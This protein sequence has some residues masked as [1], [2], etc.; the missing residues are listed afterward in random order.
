MSKKDR[1]D[2]ERELLRRLL[3]K[4]GFPAQSAETARVAT[5]EQPFPSSAQN[6][7]KMPFL[8]PL[9]YQ[10]E[11]LWFLDRFEPSSDFYNVPLAW[12]LKGD[13][14]VP[15]LERSLQEVIRRHEI[16][17]TCFVMGEDEEPKQKV[18]ADRL[19]VRLPVMDLR[20]LAPGERQERVKGV[21]A[22][23][24]GKAFDLSQAPLLRVV[25]LRTG[26]REHVLGLTLHH[27]IW[28]EWSLGVF[29]EE[30]GKLYEAYGRGEKSP[31]AE[32]GMQYREYALEQREW[33]RGGR[34]QQQMK[35]WKEQLKGMPQVLELP[36][37]H[38]RRVQQ[39]FR[40]G[41][42][43]LGL[44]SELLEGLNTL[45]RAEG[46]SLFMTLLTA[47]QVLLMR[48]TGQEVFGVGTSIT[49]R[50]RT[51]TQGLIGFFLNT[52]VIRADLGSEPAFRD[53]L[54]QVRQTALDGYEHQDLPFEKLVEELA[55]DR[56]A[57]RNPLIQVMFT[58]ARPTES[59]LGPFELSEFETDIQTSKFDLSMIVYESRQ[60]EIAFNYSTDLFEAETIR[61]MLGHYEQL[62]KAVATNPEQRVWEM[63][64]LTDPERHQLE[65][66]NQTGK[67]YDHGQ[68][69][70]ELFEQCVAR[71]PNTVAVEYEGQKFTYGELNR[72]ANRLA[73]Y[74]RELGVQAETRVA[75]CLE[76]GLAMVVG[77]VAVLK[78]GGAY[79]PMDPEYPQEHLRYMLQDCAPV[80]LLTQERSRAVLG[81]IDEKIAVVDV[82]D[83]DKFRQQPESNLQRVGT[84]L[85]AGHLAYLIYTS[86]S[87]GKPKGVMVSHQNLVSATFARRLAYGELGRFLL[88]SSFS[89]DSSVAGIFGSLMYGGTLIIAP[90]DVVRDPLCLN[91]EVE[92]L[93][94]QSLLC[95][96][97]LYKHFLEYPV[98]C[99]H[100]NL[101][102]VIVAG[103]VCPPDLVAK[104]AEKEPQV[105]L[106][107]EYGPTEGT[108]W[109]TMHRC[110][111]PM[112]RES[113]PIG[114]PIANTQ[115]HILDAK[116]GRSPIGVVGE[117]HVGGAGVARGYWNRP[118]LT[119]EKFVPDP[120]AG[121]VA[122]RMYK[123][124]DLGRWRPDG[125]IEFIGRNDSQ[126][127]IRGYRVELE[128]I[129]RVLRE[130]DAVKEAVV[131]AREDQ[132]GGQQL[133]AYVVEKWQEQRLPQEGEDFSAEAKRVQD[134]TRLYDDLYGRNDAYAYA[135]Q[136]I[137]AR[138]WSSS[139]INQPLREEE[140]AESVTQTVKSIRELGGR[141]VL[142]IG[143]GI[144]L[145]LSR[146]APH[147]DAYCG[148]DV[149]VEALRRLRAHLEGKP[150]FS[151]V[152]LREG[153]A[154]QLEDLEAERFDCV[155]LNEV[156][157]H[158]PDLD[159]LLKVLKKAA[160]LVGPRGTIFLGGMRNLHLLEAFYA[161]V[162]MFQARDSMSL[163]D[164]RRRIRHQVRWE[165][166]LI[167]APEFFAGV[168]GFLPQVTAAKVQL[169]RGQYRNEITCFKYDVTLYVGYE[170][171]DPV[172]HKEMEWDAE[173]WSI[174]GLERW[175][176]EQSPDV[177][178]IKRIANARLAKEKR[179]LELLSR[180]DGKASVA[181]IRQAL[182]QFAAKE[183]GIDPEDFF[184]VEHSL[185]Y[186]VEV[187]WAGGGYDGA[188]DVIL[189]KRSLLSR[190]FVAVEHGRGEE[191]RGEQVWA[192][193][194]EF[195]NHP[196][197]EARLRG[198][199]SRELIE[200]LRRGLKERLPE[201]M[202]P[203]AFVRLES[204]PLTANGKVDRQALPEVGELELSE[205]G[206]GYEAPRAGMEEQLAEV[207]TTVLRVTRV[208]RRDHFFRSGGHSLLAASMVSRFRNIFGI[209]VPVRA[210]FESPTIA[211]LAEVIEH[212]L[213]LQ[214]AQTG[215][216]AIASKL[217]PSTSRPSLFPLSYQQEQLWFLDRFEPSS[218][219]YNV[220]LAWT[221]KGDLDVSTL[222][223][224][225]QE[226][227][228]RHEI[229]RTCFVIGED[230][231]PRQK[232]VEK[233]D[234]MLPVVDL[235]KL[236]AGQRDQLARRVLTQEGGKAFD[237]SRAPLLRAMMVRME[238]RQH[239]LGL[240]LHHIVSDDRSLGVL[241]KELGE[242]YGAY[243]N[244]EDSPLPELGMQYGDYALEQREGLRE[245]KF[246]QQ[247]EYWKKELKGMPQV[248]ELPTDHVRPARQ[249]FRGG[250]EQII[251]QSDL[252]DGLKTLGREEKTSSFMALL[253]ILQ[254]LL[255]RY[256][257]QENF[258]V[259]T[260]VAN[261][262]RIETEQTIG[263]FLNTLVIR[264]NLE[265]EPTF[266]EVLRRVRE[267]VLGGY[268][269]QDLAFEK[270]V[271]ELAPDRDVSRTPIFQVIFTW[272]GESDKLEFGDLELGGFAV[273]LDM[274]KFD[275]TMSVS[276]TAQG[277]AVAINYATDL[278]EAET[279]RR[280]LGHYERL[281]KAV[282]ENAA[283]H[284]WRLPLLTGQEIEQLEQWNQTARDYALDKTIAGLFEE[285]A[286]RTRNA[287][288][289]E[290]EQQEL[291]YGDLNRQANRLA[292]YLIALGVKPD[293]LVAICVERSLEMVVGLLAVMKAGGAYVPLDPAYPEERLRFMLEDCRPAVLLTQGHLRGL[294]TGINES[295]RVIDLGSMETWSDQPE[296]NPEHDAIGLTAANL[297]Y[298][299]YTSGSTGTPKAVAMPLRAATNMLVWQMNESMP[300]APQRTLQFA[301]LG[302]DV[303][304]QEIFS[305]L[306]AGGTLVL[307]D[308]EKRRNS[309]DLTRYV[310]EKG[311]Q[312]LFL[313][314]V[315]LRMLAEGV[316]QIG[317]ALKQGE[318]FDCALQEINVAGE[319][320]RI[321]H[322]VRGLFKR[323]N[324]C[325]LNNHYGPTE[326]HA[327]SAFHL[328]SEE[329]NWPLLP[330]IGQPIANAHIYLLDKHE[331]LVP[332]GVTGE[333]YIGGAGVARGY[334]NR[335]ELMAGRF[336]K[337]P[338]AKE[339]EAR[340][341]RSGDIGRW[342]PDGTIEFI[343][344]NDSQ[345]KIR[346]YRV[347]LGE[348]EARL[349]QQ[350]GVRN[351]AVVAKTGTNGNRRLVAYVVG[352]REG[353]DLRRDLKGKLPGYMIPS[354]IVTLP[355]LPLSGNGKV[356]REVLEKLEDLG[357]G[358]QDYE[359]PRTALEERLS[360]TWAETLGITR[361]GRHDNFFDLGGHSLLAT[362]LVTRMENIFE[363]GVPVRALFESPT[364]AELAEQIE[365]GLKLQTRKSAE[366]AKGGTRALITSARRPS[367][368][369]LSYQQEQLWFLD[370][371]NPGNAFY[372]VPM[373]WGLKGDIDVSRLERSLQAVVRRHEI[374]R[375]CFVMGED[376]EPRQKVVESLDMPM[377]VVDL[378]KLEA[379]EREEQARRVLT[380]EAGKAFDLSR[381]P[382][383]RAIL[384]RTEDREHI[385]GLTLHHIVSD[386]WSLGVLMEELGK[387]YQAYGKGEDSPLP[388]LGMQY[389][390][391]AIEQ[392]EGL[393]EGKFQQ[394]MEYWKKELKG[395]P[396]VLEL[397]TD[398][399]RPA[400]ESFRGGTEQRIL[401]SD[402]LDGLH[403]LRRE[404]KASLLM[405]ML[406]AFQVLLMRYS[407]QDD[408]GI[409]TVVANRRRPETKGLIGFF[410][411]TL[412]IRANLGGEPT[413]RK[414]LRQVRERVLDG[415][416]HQDLAF[417]KLVEELAPDR[418]V[419][420][421]PV[422]QVA[423]ILR[424]VIAGKSEP[425]GLELVPFG[426]D[427]GT[428]K[429]DL[430][431]GVEEAAENAVIS[432]NYSADLFEAETIRHMLEHYECLLEGIVADVDQPVWALPMMSKLD[433]K[434]L[435]NWNCSSLVSR[436]EKNIVEIFDAQAQCTPQEPV[437]I[438]VETQ[439]SYAELNR[440]A[441]Q[442]G[443]YLARLGVTPEARVG[444]FMPH[445][446]E[447]MVAVL[448]VL[449]AGGA[450]LPLDVLNPKDRLRSI[451]D[452]S[453]TAMLLT[454][455]GLRKRLPQ[456]NA[457]VLCLDL[458]WEVIEQQSTTNPEVQIN[459]QN[460]ACVI[461]TAA[462]EERAK[463]LMIEHN[464]LMDLALA[465]E[466]ADPANQNG[467]A[468]QNGCPE[469]WTHLTSSS[470][471][472]GTSAFFTPVAEG[473]RARFKPSGNTEIYILDPHL[474]PVAIGVPGE[475]WIAGPAAGRAYLGWPSLTAEKFRP[476]PFK[477]EMGAR[478]CGSGE[479]ARYREDG[480]VEFLGRFDD[481][482]EVQGLQV[483][484]GEIETALTNYENVREAVVVVR[485][486]G[487][488][489]AYIVVCDGKRLGQN[490][491]RSHLDSRL[492]AYMI[493][494]AFITLQEL[495]RNAR[496]EVDRAAL[497]VLVQEQLT[498]EF[499]LPRTE[500]EQT[501]ASAWQA[502]L[503]IDQVGV[504]DNFFDLGGHSL[505]MIRLHQKLR[506]ELPGEIELLHL[507]QFPTIGSLVRF[508]HTGYNF[509]GKSR[510]T[511]ERAGRQK[512]AV[513]KLKRMHTA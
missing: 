213:K 450:Y 307:I 207:W 326:T 78:A 512:G 16:L 257:G 148:L 427:P 117:L 462:S 34:F 71:T 390:E 449:K 235:R 30:W 396:Q 346:G 57:A 506:A 193:E 233:L 188:Y 256:T 202:I 171:I 457:R 393:R 49:T 309:T 277:A 406:A 141:R 502:I 212:G 316:A 402:L 48:Y 7:K 152:V 318:R 367:F 279:I 330:P 183:D 24:A 140:I 169:K 448:G 23:E 451:I 492:P 501:I 308:E 373:T 14:N 363:I 70:G 260:P 504:H 306:G 376:E 126:V 340:M 53:A 6:S 163:E 64:L 475:L 115:I 500:L 21:I 432:M 146:I 467:H 159:Y 220:P 473:Q 498:K 168:N 138:V 355:E 189:T 81:G 479:R 106:F 422:F 493:P 156:A 121:N 145:L 211:E 28:D 379:G 438:S 431:L 398:H 221:L 265:G 110:V 62:L 232:V 284:V 26:E 47:F 425:G 366:G 510:E 54:R 378:R 347:E 65:Q 275:L 251:L 191:G 25:L 93:G 335:P 369:P 375:T 420:R 61:R 172:D 181:E 229:L 92:R 187:S 460:L 40:G 60:A 484:L 495:P 435:S 195:A 380:E 42:L 478:M 505:L 331:Q 416:E 41:M 95:V 91:Q 455:E 263:F 77:L 317:A 497:S 58:L 385:L 324:H 217:A 264:A 86:G 137:N 182:G 351:C 18:A 314:Y 328:D 194:A 350:S 310:M 36:T 388:E 136:A 336:V 85:Q 312:R 173:K 299:I 204:L 88:L 158:F 215:D 84:G 441:N 387:L 491:V 216:T 22:E 5:Q 160:E 103:E 332:L 143:C 488:L 66:W 11:Q 352:E 426:L 445:S 243:G 20:E 29:I 223:R 96:P 405:I 464:G 133:V 486:N 490:E 395:M 259:G 494:G 144:G 482:A 381:P 132:A 476:N 125:I 203:S 404:E 274:S 131:T 394:Q 371:F 362:L 304:F 384:V 10:Q 209:D 419:S 368:F 408:F 282:V 270:L 162:Q 458:E 305:T 389:G 228:R 119:A 298:V 296:S 134:F 471:L 15:I 507:F 170:R 245:G 69:A 32:L 383:L 481:R 196:M 219:F 89:F 334:L 13:L 477:S 17:R 122:A 46:A 268:E 82:N 483:E 499:V 300:A 333:L 107:N 206:E 338:F 377:P 417:E 192:A 456:T 12:T 56:D 374:L 391:Y 234:V 365:H 150:E 468:R 267:A 164:L 474:Q 247:M 433:E 409:G 442:V 466:A 513:Q 240:T 511:R 98:R 4:E 73:H 237:L 261:R 184:S 487:D 345:V 301:A 76:R 437:V 428:S 290:Y 302:F 176:Q 190:D 100:K 225:L 412:V 271:E 50:S 101:S 186:Q 111:H 503:G 201:H 31:L 2:E 87:T 166:D 142:E 354:V 43:H 174:R 139:Y 51:N 112:G 45:A 90:R 329:E 415:Y 39:S 322:K 120:L 297:V 293:V 370:R 227:V 447:M 465:H 439:L 400:R 224:S 286:S 151:H 287:V 99:E 280:M 3:E 210:I 470:F 135:D 313:P 276:E 198:Q 157:Q 266:R 430:I 80:V 453:D 323:L 461:Y 401:Q 392:R 273:D 127:K 238:D 480:T 403:A 321:D 59:E 155:V 424:R 258:G 179:L 489:V 358:S 55:P 348:I 272:L 485:P 178:R 386:D 128:E 262:K 359:A 343:G 421:S 226:V 418:D 208:G 153:A 414:V 8:F 315:G 319:Q 469:I 67:D 325:R 303:S 459:P 327:A 250:T 185:P 472:V 161:S 463:G 104:S 222:E 281:V 124:G 118:E 357:L 397:P 434:V 218:D 44:K 399:V 109:A 123:T 382:L 411:N 9:S 353:E 413:F 244:G 205:A 154:H 294:F 283:Q 239:I 508:L 94:V 423:F 236:E 496:G 452:S 83:A 341:Y 129:E 63:P 52:L 105:E 360:E 443:N 79:V 149:S 35:Y 292:H 214:R 199:F 255:M 342:R 246:Q 410:L 288:A 116:G 285:H 295:L 197:A 108:V 75:I 97:S 37:D 130:Q 372:N 254:V 241:M 311:I 38:P 230:E 289:V 248:L 429:F 27:I 68:N 291:K 356:D 440:R 113:V 165:K 242:L 337:D 102:R 167:V 1:L 74:L 320:L 454:L 249:S 114:R 253:A 19:E 436:A 344:R 200:A 446:Q 361:V 33:L 407:G 231:E 180:N 252:L 364:I 177:V 269:H 147:C 509:D 339:E 444:I 175:L 72:R 349:Q 278:F